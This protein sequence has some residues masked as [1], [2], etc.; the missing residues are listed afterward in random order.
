MNTTTTN[1]NAIRIAARHRTLV[2]RT[3]LATL[4]LSLGVAAYSCHA[5]AGI[6]AAMPASGVQ[7]L[8][9]LS[10]YSAPAESAAVD[11]KAVAVT[12]PA[13]ATA[14]DTSVSKEPELAPERGALELAGGNGHMTHGYGHARMISL[15]GMAVTSAGVVQGELTQQ[16]RFGF[17]GNYGNLSLTHDFSQDYYSTVAVGT[18]N[19]PLFPSWRIDTTGYRKFGSERQYVAGVGAYYAKGN[20]SARA[21]QGLLFTGI[22]YHKGL[23]VE[24]GLRLNW[25]D[26]GKILGPSQYIAATFGSDD[27]RAIIVR[28]EHAKETYKVLPG[29]SALVNFKSNTANVQWR[30]RITRDSMLLAGL[31]YYRSPLYDR[32]SFNLGWR[33][34]FR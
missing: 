13:A 18:G 26:P 33:W 14:T 21:D 30:E 34:S 17:S 6:D 2:A 8:R 15:H 16:S 1:N 3:A 27:R 23:V 5:A 9:L 24:G 4:G 29:G 20:E 10:L 28:Y 7:P 32:L 25:A 12:D 11:D 31:E 22:V 19:S